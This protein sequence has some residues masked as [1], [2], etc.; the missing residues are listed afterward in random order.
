MEFDKSRL[1]GTVTEDELASASAV[2]IAIITVCATLAVVARL[3]LGIKTI[4]YST[5]V[6]GRYI[7][8]LIV[9]M[10]GH[11]LNHFIAIAFDIE[12]FAHTALREERPNDGHGAKV[13]CLG[14]H[15]LSAQ[16]HGQDTDLTSWASGGQFYGMLRATT[17]S[18]HPD[19]VFPTWQFLSKFAMPNE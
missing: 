5:L 6:C 11:H 14:G 7:V 9:R 4:S 19:S 2:V 8:N 16:R 12:A 3:E 15:E 13:D 17:V 10:V 18:R 1:G